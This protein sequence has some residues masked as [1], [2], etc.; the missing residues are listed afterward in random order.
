MPNDQLD[1]SKLLAPHEPPQALDHRWRIT[2]HG[3]QTLAELRENLEK[4]RD[5]YANTTLVAGPDPRA[6][7]QNLRVFGWEH[8]WR[9]QT[10]AIA[11][12]I[13]SIEASEEYQKNAGTKFRVQINGHTIVSPPSDKSGNETLTAITVAE[14]YDRA[15]EM[16]KQ[17]AAW[18]AENPEDAAAQQAAAQLAAVPGSGERR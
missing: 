7:N 12:A 2:G 18:A 14:V 6:P 17:Y 16:A 8:V 11:G 15:E 10:S 4:E 9:H 5:H 3:R 1:V 13:A